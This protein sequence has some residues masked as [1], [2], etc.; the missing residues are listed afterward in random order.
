MLKAAKAI[1][2]DEFYR[3]KSR[4]D[5]SKTLGHGSN[6]MGLPPTMSRHSH[7][8]VGLVEHFQKAYFTAFPEIPQWHSWVIEQVQTTATITTMLGRTRQ[9]F[10]RPND[11]ATIREAVAYEPQSVA[12]D[13]CNQA[14]LSLHKM[15]MA[16]TFPAQIF[17]SKHDEIGV[18]FDQA[19]EAEVLKIMTEVMEQRITL[20]SPAGETRWWYVP[21]EA[22]SGWNLGRRV[23]DKDTGVITNPNGLS[24]PDSARVRAAESGWRDWIL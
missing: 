6:Y 17:L 16:G 5:V 18:R 21:A 23:V 24:H 13:Y 11:A 4:R 14:L 19:L 2:S 15:S 22:E 1:A 3:G 20:T 8:D 9:F 10:G 7:I 12:A